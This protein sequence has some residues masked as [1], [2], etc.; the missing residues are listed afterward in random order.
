VNLSGGEKQRLAL[1]RGILA[2]AHSQILL[3][4]EPTSSMDSVN[5]ARIYKNLFTNFKDRCVVSSIHR[6]HLLHSFDEIYVL[7]KGTVIERGS[8][9]E[10]LAKNGHL[11]RMWD[12]YQEASDKDLGQRT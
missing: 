9:P 12:E 2:A 6:L 8:L 10:L 7:E 11:K 1:A 3:L 5:E 4:D